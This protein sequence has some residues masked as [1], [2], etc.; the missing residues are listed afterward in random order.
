MLLFYRRVWTVH[1]SIYAR[2][3]ALC[4]QRGPVSSPMAEWSWDHHN[5]WRPRTNN[6]P[7]NAL[8]FRAQEYWR[9]DQ[10]GEYP[11]TAVRIQ[12]E[13]LYFMGCGRMAYLQ[14]ARKAC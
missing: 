7:N 5:N 2:E 1:S 13:D 10:N 12:E 11:A 8:L 3:K 6:K 9:D 4:P 14:G